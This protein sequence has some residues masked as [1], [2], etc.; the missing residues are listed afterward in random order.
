VRTATA[1]LIRYPGHDDWT[2]LFDLTTD[3]YETR[4]LIDEPAARGLRQQMEAEFERQ[5]KLVQFRFPPTADPLPEAGNR[6]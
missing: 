4:N 1:K 5:S 3:P 2:E 6:P